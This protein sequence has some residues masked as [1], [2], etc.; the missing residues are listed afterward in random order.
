MKLIFR[1]TNRRSRLCVTIESLV[2]VV[3]LPNASFDVEVGNL[4]AFQPF[5][6][7]KGKVK[8]ESCLSH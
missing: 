8:V 5:V 7:V 2:L 6:G 3:S 4:V 1:N